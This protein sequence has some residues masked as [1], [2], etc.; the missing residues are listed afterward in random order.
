MSSDELS[1]KT[2]FLTPP[3]KTSH[4]DF[5]EKTKFLRTNDQSSHVPLKKVI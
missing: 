1:L 5:K 3:L 2:D 4:R